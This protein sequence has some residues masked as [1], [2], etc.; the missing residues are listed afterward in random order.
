MKT[1]VWFSLSLVS[2][3]LVISDL[4]GVIQANISSSYNSAV[5]SSH[6]FC[7]DPVNDPSSC[8]AS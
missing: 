4:T 5:A 7:D 6:E 2:A 1:L 8:R 3:V